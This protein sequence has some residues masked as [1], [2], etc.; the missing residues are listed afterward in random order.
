MRKISSWAKISKKAIIEDEVIIYPFVVIEDNVKIGRG[1]EIF[2]NV[3]ILK[4]TE[5]GENNKIYPGCVLGVLPFDLKYQGEESY[6]KIGNNNIIH[7]GTTISKATGKGEATIIGDNNFIMAYIHIAHNCKI[8]NN[9]IITNHTQIG[10]HCEIFDYVN[11]GGNCGI[12][13]YVRIGSYA[14]VGAFSYLKKD[15]LPFMIGEGNPFRVYGINSIGLLRANFDKEKIAIL[16]KV[17]KIIYFSKFNL[18][19]AINYINENLPKIPEIEL[20]IDFIKK[21]KRGI[22]L[23]SP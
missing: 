10:G 21:T 11:I 19:Q 6:L 23:R 14:F 3:I 5:I 12:H 16:K 22:C 17:Y 20:I 7:E 8:G 15:L 4:G 2:S 1:T 13:Q 9:N 18:S